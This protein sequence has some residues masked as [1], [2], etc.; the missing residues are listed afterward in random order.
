MAV[1]YSIINLYNITYIFLDIHITTL[2][3]KGIFND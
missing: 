1:L 3:L 2:I